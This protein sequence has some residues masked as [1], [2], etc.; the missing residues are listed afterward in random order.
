MLLSA[1]PSMVMT[2]LAPTAL[3]DVTQ[4]RILCPSGCTVHAPHSAMP[5][6]NFVPVS[7]SV[8]RST[9]SSGMAGS[10]STSVSLPLMLSLITERLRHRS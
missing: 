5:Q 8:S 3:T 7:A 4:E 10:T 9:H 6:P 1:D 2:F